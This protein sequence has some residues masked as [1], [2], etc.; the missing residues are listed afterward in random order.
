M[1]YL[2]REEYTHIPA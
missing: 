2:E 1:S